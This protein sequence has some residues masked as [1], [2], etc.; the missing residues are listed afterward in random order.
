LLAAATIVVL[1]R[2]LSTQEYAFVTLF[3][4][5]AWLISSGVAGGISMRYLRERSEQVSRG[6]PA[7]E[8]ASFFGA[9]VK[10]V[11]LIALLGAVGLPLGLLVD[12]GASTAGSLALGALAVA[13]AIGLGAVELA[14]LHQQAHRRFLVAG[15]FGLSRSA[16]LLGVAIVVTTR[17][18]VSTVQLAMWLVGGLALIAIAAIVPILIREARAGSMSAAGLRFTR[19]E[20]WLSLYYLGAAGFAHVDALVAGALLEDPEVAALG[21]AM[22]YLA[23]VLGAIPALN[24]MLKVRTSQ[25]DIVDSVDNQR[26]IVVGWL[27]RAVLPA[28]AIF[29]IA[30]AAS[31]FVIDYVDGGRYPNSQVVFQIFLIIPLA[32][33]VTLPAVNVLMAQRRFALL[34]GVQGSALLLNLVG[35]AAIAP[36]Y[37]ITGIAVVS[38]TV[39]VLLEAVTVAASLGAGQRKRAL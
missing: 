35:D 26:R 7:A 2:G 6:T 34:A 29:G 32:V 24:A 9:L 25:V 11:L 4:A 16:V 36:Y 13:Y 20:R 5:I 18:P 37:G 12:L 38:A 28:A 22:R 39:Y 19:E 21:A 17:S 23:L 31:P 8:A 27:R 33:Y 10:T 14:I 3:L 30:A 1:I 15:C